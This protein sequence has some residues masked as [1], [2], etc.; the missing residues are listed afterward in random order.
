MV[1]SVIVVG[2]GSAGWITANLL[3]TYI[4]RS[5]R[6]ISLT[7]V[8]S[9]DIPT[10][11]VGEAT[12]PTI[13]RTLQT[14]GLS[15]QDVLLS[16]DATFK[17]LIRFSDWNLG[18]TY[19]HPFDRRPRPHTDA[20]ANFWTAQYGKPFDKTFSVLSN[21]SDDNLSPKHPKAPQYQGHFP[22]AY[23]LDAI[24]LA[25]R[26]AEHGR[27]NGIQHKL[28][29]IKK[30]HLSEDG[31]IDTLTTDKDETLKAD[32]YVDC[33]GFRSLLL[34]D[35]LGVKARNYGKYLLCDRAVA[36]QVPYDVWKPSKILPYT[37]ATARDFGWQWDINL[38]T[39]RGTGYVY[40]SAFL[41]ET[42]AEA[43][44][45]SFEGAHC[46][47]IPA[48]HIKYESAKRDVSWFKNCVAI[49]LS[50][51]F[52]EPLESSGLYFIEIAA[53]AVGIML[54]DYCV[55]PDAT[56]N[57]FNRVI[58]DL[59]EEI[60]SFIN[61]HYVISN[62]RDTEFWRAATAP[63]AFVDDLKDKIEV[64]KNRS[65]NQLDFGGAQRL[66]SQ[67]SFEFILHGMNWVNPAPKMPAP[68]MPDMAPVLKKN[69]SELPD[70]DA[71]L[72]LLK[73]LRK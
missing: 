70:H 14:I 9:P 15:E 8:E 61:L 69:R 57:H 12:V 59:Y 38:Q 3:N 23:H 2:G 18:E 48:R 73:P 21:L 34:G 30:V 50:D 56:R 25:L 28:C 39:R 64:W 19:D 24:K 71:F 4:K 63:E 40:S 1:K 27:Q 68:A 6:Q 20:A 11:G 45:R 42:Y 26:L 47:D 22:Y 58:N 62:R 16:A 46:K 53:Q 67:D 72:D 5:G 36:M 66:F 35:T 37:K 60:L 32:L 52:L 10:I 49:G 41:S 54:D 13:R 43:A 31:A 51:G 7:V 33:T 29:Q 17:S 55:T 65:P 44:L